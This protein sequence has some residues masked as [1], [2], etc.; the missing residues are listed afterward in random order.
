MREVYLIRWIDAYSIDKWHP[1]EEMAEKFDMGFMVHSVG[2]LFEES[3]DYISLLQNV[4][5]ESVSG[6]INIPRDCIREKT[7]LYE[8][9]E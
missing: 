8:I 3:D 6:M 2:F 5:G 7:K 1:K 9:E 4:E